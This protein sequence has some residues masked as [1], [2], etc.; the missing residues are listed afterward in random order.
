MKKLNFYLTEKQYQKLQEI[1]RST[2]LTMAEI[3]RRAMD[4]YLEQRK[5][6]NNEV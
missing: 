2:G 3:I 5:E 6:T 4:M 1:S